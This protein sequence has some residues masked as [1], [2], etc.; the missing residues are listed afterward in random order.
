MR[1]GFAMTIILVMLCSMIAL[2]S[3]TADAEK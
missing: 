1:P 3:D 2:P